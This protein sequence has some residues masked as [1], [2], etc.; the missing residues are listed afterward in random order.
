LPA[1]V[2][3]TLRSLS[4]PIRAVSNRPEMLCE[5]LRE[6]CLVFIKSTGSPGPYTKLF[7]HDFVLRI[8][9]IRRW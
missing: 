8:L 4:A 5:T 2:A 3:R 6:S 9:R 1:V 7:W